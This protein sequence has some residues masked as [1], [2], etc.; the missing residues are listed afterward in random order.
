MTKQQKQAYSGTE[1]LRE[2]LKSLVGGKYQLDCKC[3][4]TIGHQFSNDIVIHGN[5]KKQ[6]LTI[7]CSQCAY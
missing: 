2:A 3:H 4:T 1:A 5:G 7:T 6:P